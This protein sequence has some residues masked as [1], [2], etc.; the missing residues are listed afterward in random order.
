MDYSNIDYDSTFDI[1]GTPENYINKYENLRIQNNIKAAFLCLF[2][3]IKAFPSNY[4]IASELFNVLFE[5]KEYRDLIKFSHFV[6]V[7]VQDE[8]IIKQCYG[9]LGCCYYFL[10]NYKEALENFEKA[11]GYCGIFSKDMP[12][13]Y[14]QAICYEKNGEYKKALKLITDLYNDYSKTIMDVERTNS[15]AGWRVTEHYIKNE[16]MHLLTEAMNRIR[17]S[18]NE[19]IVYEITI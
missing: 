15:E 12:T 11:D 13:T 9:N 7:N 1:I 2:H 18:L 19:D 5:Y 3:A 14:Y 8:K 4:K 10:N 17:T 16:T 6:L